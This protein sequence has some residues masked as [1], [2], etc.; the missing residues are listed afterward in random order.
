LVAEA[1]SLPPDKRQDNLLKAEDV[2]L[3]DMPFLLLYFKNTIRASN[4]KFDMPLH[5]LQYR[6][7]KYAQKK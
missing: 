1:K 5:P 7:Y 6:F 2:I 4:E 3:N